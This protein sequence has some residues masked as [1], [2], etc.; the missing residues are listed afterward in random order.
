MQDADRSRRGSDAA[1]GRQGSEN[2]R[3]VR[4]GKTRK[5][6][7][8]PKAPVVT[9]YLDGCHLTTTHLRTPSR[10]SQLPIDLQPHYHGSTWAVFSNRRSTSLRVQIAGVQRRRVTG[11]LRHRT[12]T[13]TVRLTPSTETHRQTPQ[14]KFGAGTALDRASACKCKTTHRG[15]FSGR[16]GRFPGP[17]RFSL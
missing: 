17:R 16:S 14:Q 6:E 12:G 10:H 5:Y 15:E 7:L 4:I 3:R 9:T 2:K 11:P 8:S 13:T 1:A